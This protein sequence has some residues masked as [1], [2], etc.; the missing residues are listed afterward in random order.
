MLGNFGDAKSVG[1]G[2]LELRIAFGPGY[3]VYF[4]EDGDA[5]VVLLCSGTKRTPVADVRRAKGYWVDYQGLV[6]DA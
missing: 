6:K 5:I 1:A 4:A 3:R 2:V